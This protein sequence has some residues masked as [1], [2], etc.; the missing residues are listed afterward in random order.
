MSIIQTLLDAI[1]LPPLWLAA[2]MIWKIARGR[3]YDWQTARNRRRNN[4]HYQ[5]ERAKRRRNNEY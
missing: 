2:F 1:V 4:L 5:R 3:F